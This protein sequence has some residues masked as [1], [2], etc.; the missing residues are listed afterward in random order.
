MYTVCIKDLYEISIVYIYIYIYIY[1]I[2]SL[3]FDTH[4][5]AGNCY[6]NQ[7]SSLEL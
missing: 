3:L 1:I 7:K 5:N 4:Y 2:N 6:E